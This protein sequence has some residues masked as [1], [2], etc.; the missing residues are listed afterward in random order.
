MNINILIG[1]DN[2]MINQPDILEEL[3]FLKFRY[4]KIDFFDL[5][6]MTTYNPRKVLNLKC[7]IPQLKSIYEIIV[8]D[9]NLNIV[10]NP[11]DDRGIK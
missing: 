6:N 3:K 11:W 9:E 4:K 5:L 10:Y 2:A 7:D 1:T 8:L